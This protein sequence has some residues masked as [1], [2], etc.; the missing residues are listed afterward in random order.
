[1]NC[2]LKKFSDSYLYNV[3]SPE[4]E[5]RF[6]PAILSAENELKSSNISFLKKALRQ[7]VNRKVD[8]IRFLRVRRVNPI[9]MFEI[10]FNLR[11]FCFTRDGKSK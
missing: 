6:Q 2:R 5:N 7:F 9:L 11:K 3:S 8:F 4:D 1:M 10:D